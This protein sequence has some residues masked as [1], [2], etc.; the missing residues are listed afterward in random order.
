M[1]TINIEGKEY[2]ILK[3]QEVTVYLPIHN[4]QKIVKMD[5]YTIKIDGKLKEVPSYEIKDVIN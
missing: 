2:K 3:T 4:E 1:K 5:F